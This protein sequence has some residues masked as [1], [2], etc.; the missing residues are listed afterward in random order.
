MR[1]KIAAQDRYFPRQ[2]RAWVT[3]SWRVTVRPGNVPQGLG[4]VDK[5]L[6]ITVFDRIE[7]SCKINNECYEVCMRMEPEEFRV[8]VQWPDQ[9]EARLGTLIEPPDIQE[10]CNHTTSRPSIRIARPGV[11]RLQTTVL[12]HPPAMICPRSTA[13]PHRSLL[14]RVGLLPPSRARSVIP[15][16]TRNRGSARGCRGW[17]RERRLAGARFSARLFAGIGVGAREHLAACG[18][19][20]GLSSKSSRSRRRCSRIEPRQLVERCSG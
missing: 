12:F 1:E 2:L 8:L 15:A 18:R 13:P 19:R 9:V 16:G 17:L 14:R 7:K 20:L 4:F 5:S 10:H 3:S 6:Q 11:G